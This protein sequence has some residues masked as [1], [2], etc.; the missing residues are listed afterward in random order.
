MFNQSNAMRRMFK[1]RERIAKRNPFFASILFG[2]KMIE[3]KQR[4]TIG[5]NGIDI[6]FNPDYVTDAQNDPYL[7]GQLLKSVMHCAMLHLGRRRWRDMDRWNEAASYPVN[8]VISDYFKLAP[9]ALYNKKYGEMAPEAV[10]ELLEQQKQ[11]GG[12]GKG[13]SQKGKSPP[14]D[15]DE[16]G[17]GEGESSGQDGDQEQPGGM[18]EGEATPDEMEQAE[19][20]WKRNLSNAIEKST[21][22]GT[23]PG[24]LQRLIGDLFPKEKINWREII[25]DW[26]RDAKSNTVRTWQRPNRRRL[27]NGEYMPGNGIDQIF[28]LV[29][30]LDVSGSVSQEMIQEMCSEA[31]SL[32]NQNLVNQITLISVDTRIHNT[33][34]ARNEDDI[35]GWNAGGGGGTN[36]RSAMAEI[37]K[38]QD[39]VGLIFLTDM[40]TSSFGEEPPFPVA[41]VD[42]AGS[43]AKAPFGMTIPYK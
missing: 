37:G 25:R 41:W 9:D 30:C 36:F 43:G 13:K 42:W 1:A 5:T 4:K 40:Y 32:L 19:R 29:M 11:Q 3:T 2:A 35:K 31:A 10:Y 6:Y 20:D 18:F 14:Q 28:N 34:V 33:L 17:D 21:K 38:M 12:G 39:V 22:A 16:D 24:N 8:Q 27:G 23:M 26:S 15:G 7:E